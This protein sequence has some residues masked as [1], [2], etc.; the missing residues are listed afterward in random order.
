MFKVIGFDF[1]GV[2]IESNEIKEAGFK[3][4][5]S[6]YPTHYQKLVSYHE[7]SVGVPRQEKMAHAIKNILKTDDPDLLQKWLSYYQ[8]YTRSRLVKCEF[9]PGS[10]ETLE[11]Y[12]KTLPLYLVSATPIDELE[13]IVDQRNLRKYFVEVFGNPIRKVEHFRKILDLEKVPRNEFLYIGD[14]LDDFNASQKVGIS[15]I[16]RSGKSTFQ[17]TGA[18]V[19]KDLVGVKEHLDGLYKQAF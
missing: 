13:W 17:G 14:S 3:E 9:V 11:N 5:F 6:R 8:N 10:L 18:L 12:S 4:I 7:S 16:G 15:F 1:D 19:F 2:I